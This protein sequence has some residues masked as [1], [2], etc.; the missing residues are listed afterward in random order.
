VDTFFS[1]LNLGY[2]KIFWVLSYPILNLV[3]VSINLNVLSFLSTH[4]STICKYSN[5]GVLTMFGFN[6]VYRLKSSSDYRRHIL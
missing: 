5:L 1:Y 3:Y 2:M 6:S 4:I